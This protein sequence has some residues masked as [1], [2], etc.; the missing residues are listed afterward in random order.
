MK[1][2]HFNKTRWEI[3]KRDLRENN[4]GHFNNCLQMWRLG[5]SSDK[6]YLYNFNSNNPKEYLS[7]CSSSLARFINQ[8]YDVIL[9]NK[10][11]FEKV[12]SQYIDVPKNFGFIKNSRVF[13]LMADLPLDRAES[14]I[15]LCQDQALVIK[16]ID[17][18]QG[19]GI[20]IMQIIDGQ[21]VLNGIPM[22]Q[23]EFTAYIKG[24]DNY[25]ISQYIKQG[26]FPSSLYPGSVNTMRI[27]MMVD[28]ISNEPFIAAAAHRIGGKSSM[29]IDNF[30]Q[31]GF[32]ANIDLDTGRLGMAACRG[33]RGQLDWHE[34]HPDTGSQI[35][36]SLIPNW[37]QIKEKL[38]F[39]MK[40]L[41][42]IRYIGWDVLLTD[43]GITIIEGNNTPIPRMLQIHEPLL[44]KP[45]VKDFY[46]YYGVV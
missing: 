14:I 31:G 11:I 32:S 1:R 41:P 30:S 29:G 23:E 40:K 5:F 38:V 46:S 42:Y 24:L 10:L 21:I 25:I 26:A 16:P 36:G 34:N 33:D 35:K 43:D 3:I 22:G 44:S 18:A 9:N 6:Y 27:L 20:G 12:L 13:P 37:D 28:P 4:L 15:N 2:N 7:D 39:V 19:Q 45:R 8:P 17:G